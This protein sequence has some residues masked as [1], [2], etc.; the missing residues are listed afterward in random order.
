MGDCIMAFWNAPF[1]DENHA[2]HAGQSAL[3]MQQFLRTTPGFEEIRVGIG[4]NTGNACVGNMGSEQ[5]FDYTALGDEV[6]LA[7]RIEGLSKNY[8]VTALVGQNTFSAAREFAT[9]EID[10]I[11]VKGKMKP[12]KIFALLGDT[13]LKDQPLF[14]E[15]R[16]HFEKMLTF[17]REQKWEEAEK[18]LENC[19][20]IT[21]PGID[22]GV[23][24]E[25][26]VSRILSCKINPPAPGWEGVTIAGSK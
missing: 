15:V 18:A 3:A 25:L 11:R 6:N 12:V 22:L 1:E 24:Y 9:L 10:L 23:L 8:G 4:I 5:R 2:P 20:R 21:L 16:G 19:R 14:G 7:S 26:Y 17:Y 13:V